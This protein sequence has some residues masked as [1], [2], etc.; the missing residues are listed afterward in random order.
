MSVGERGKRQRTKGKLANEQRAK[1][2]G[3]IS[4]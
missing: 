1:D 4:N 2:K 3:Q